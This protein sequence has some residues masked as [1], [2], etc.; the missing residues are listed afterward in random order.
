MITLL[1]AG[2]LLAACAGAG[3]DGTREATVEPT[4]DIVIVPTVEATHT[5]EATEM[6]EE[7]EPV[8]TDEIGTPAA[9]ET[10][11][12]T[13]EA[14]KPVPVH[15]PSLASNI[16]GTEI[17]AANGE[18]VGHIDSLVLNSITG[19]IV[20]LLVDVDD[21]LVEEQGLSALPWNSFQVADT[22]DDEADRFVYNAAVD[23]LAGIPV[24]DV[25]AEDFSLA[26]PAWDD[27]FVAFW[28]GAGGIPNT[29]DTET[30]AIRLTDVTDLQLLDANSEDI[31]DVEDLILDTA[32]GQVKYVIWGAGGFLD[33]G[34]DLIPL[35]FSHLRYTPAESGDQMDPV[36]TFML[37]VPREQ[38][39]AAPRFA[40]SDIPEIS[41]AGWDSEIQQFWSQIT[42]E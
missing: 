17:Q 32:A 18:T 39:E 2:L 21:G 20:Y 5:P 14:M 36:N 35:P 7:T 40:G 25:D 4:E 9:E 42:P 13:P 27:D 30:T 8:I 16:L 29:G 22:E 31:G 24:V 38:L 12:G 37:S 26:D 19:E 41:A 34:E 3:T 10:A 6:V 15:D 23:T 1:L 33:L 11:E 28:G